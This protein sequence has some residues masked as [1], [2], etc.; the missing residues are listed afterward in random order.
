M[1][2]RSPVFLLVPLLLGAPVAWAQDAS[3]EEAPPRPEPAPKASSQRLS[4]TAELDQ[5]VEL[6]MAG[7]YERCTAELSV[8]LDPKSRSPFRDAGAIERG[9][10]YFASCSLLAG[11]RERARAALRAALEANPLMSAPDSLTFPPPVVSLFL[12]VRDEVEALIAKREQEHLAEL[13]RQADEAALA[14]RKKVEQEQLLYKLAAEETVIVQ[15][16][17]VLAMLP[18]GAGQ[19]QNGDETLGIVFAASELVLGVVL[20]ASAARHAEVYGTAVLYVDSY[21]S[22]PPSVREAYTVSATLAVAST[23]ALI[24]VTALGIV[25]ANLN[26]RKEK[27]LGVRPRPLPPG[28]AP[29]PKQSPE[30]ST[31][32]IRLSP[33]LAVDDKG[34]YLGV[35]GSF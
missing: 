28:L 1:N 9:R 12:E 35:R 34:G 15:N 32:T 27:V 22:V 31:R 14:E 10:L 11:D 16:T 20:V 21:Q 8:F 29:A 6:Y 26:F 7:E 30:A 24:G 19:F 18:F 25:E 33:I 4:D 3:P 13:R 5:L 2:L 23:F 17:R